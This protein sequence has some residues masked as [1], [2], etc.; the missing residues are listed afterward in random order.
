M[1]E[2]E[3][4]LAD[5]QEQQPATRGSVSGGVEG[6]RRHGPF[7]LRWP[8]RCRV[9]SDWRAAAAVGSRNV[10][11]GLD[12]DAFTTRCFPERRRHDLQVISAYDAY[13]M[14]ATAVPAQR[15]ESAKPTT[16]SVRQVT[17]EDGLTYAGTPGPGY[18]R[19]DDVYELPAAR[20]D[21]EVAASVG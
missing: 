20:Q 12:W 7:D 9:D 8:A 4:A 10:A 1:A 14:I 6:S 17:D 16:R 2:T 11:E 19:R 5:S 18:R 15:V 3:V 13:S 21:L